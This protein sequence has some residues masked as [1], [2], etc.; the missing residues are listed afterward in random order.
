MSFNAHNRPCKD[1]CRDIFVS[2]QN[3]ERFKKYLGLGG[4]QLADIES[5]LSTGIVTRDTTKFD[6]WERDYPDYV[7][8]TQKANQLG[9]KGIDDDAAVVEGNIC[10]SSWKDWRG[11]GCYQHQFDLVNADFCGL[12]TRS[13]FRWVSHML[14]YG[15]TD[16]ARVAFTFSCNARGGYTHDLHQGWGIMEISNW[17]GNHLCVPSN[18]NKSRRVPIQINYHSGS[19]AVEFLRNDTIATIVTL[20]EAAG[21]K[22]DVQTVFYKEAHSSHPMI[23]IMLQMKGRKPKI[24]SLAAH[25]AHVTMFE[26]ERDSERASLSIGRPTSSSLLNRS[27]IYEWILNDLRY[28]QQ[29]T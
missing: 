21:F 7:R 28:S 27:R 11:D 15:I 12:M 24:S 17:G 10:R 23:F 14:S 1:V 20:A 18:R 22:F 13:V 29:V 6:S 26:R 16:D 25:K 8:A 5:A 4:P 3:G 9:I 19:R 2:R